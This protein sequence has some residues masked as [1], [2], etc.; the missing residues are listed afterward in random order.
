[1]VKSNN[2]TSTKRKTQ[3]GGVSNSC[4]GNYA[5]NDGGVNYSSLN[6]Q[7]SLDNTTMLY[8]NSI[9]LGNNI[10]GGSISETMI[11][12]NNKCGDEGVGTTNFKTE[13]F[14]Q[15]LEN[16]NSNFNINTSGGF[17]KMQKDNKKNKS[18][19][20]ISRKRA[21]SQKG[22]GYSSDPSEF[23]GGQPVYKQYDDCCPP[24]IVGGQ[25]QFGS[26]DQAVCGFG[27]VKGGG[28]RKRSRKLMNKSK[29]SKHTISKRTRSKSNKSKSIKYKN[30]RKTKR[31]SQHGGDF[32]SIGNSK[33]AD[34]DTAFNG[35]MGVFKYPDDM[36]T[37]NFAASQP[38]WDPSG[39]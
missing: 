39:L 2:K 15:Y 33:P 31:G 28:R 6:P 35:P 25:L 36:S 5:G 10:V 23:I 9:S 32:I 17:N 8:G 18:S 22:S 21:Y 24:A 16:L 7:A 34:Y 3:K 27:A 11:G 30:H 20:S 26:P 19:K 37:R 13:T 1:M 29:K 38:V 4:I 12:G 14:K